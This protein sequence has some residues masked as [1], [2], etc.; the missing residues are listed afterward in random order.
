[1]ASVS[2]PLYNLANDG[3]SSFIPSHM[4][5]TD[6]E[7]QEARRVLASIRILTMAVTYFSRIDPGRVHRHR[8]CH[9][10]QAHKIHPSF[11]SL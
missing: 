8:R 10:R 4:R 2:C 7:L 5:T 9:A 6:L 3:I 1:M 11:C